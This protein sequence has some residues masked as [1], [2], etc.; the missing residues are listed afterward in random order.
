MAKRVLLTIVLAVLAMSPAAAQEYGELAWYSAR[1]DVADMQNSRGQPLAKIGAVIQQD[2]AN[3]HRFGIRQA[4]DSDDG[5]F[6]DRAM[7]AALPNLVD[8]VG[9]DN[10]LE[11]FINRRQPFDIEVY[12]CGTPGRPSVAI[13]IPTNVIGGH[14]G[15]Y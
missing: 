8:V 6:S 2:R 1:I 15:C 9:G 5:I 13:V 4:R 7:R 12:V 11:T 10:A 3:F 14:S